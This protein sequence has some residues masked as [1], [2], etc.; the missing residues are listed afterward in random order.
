M[1]TRSWF[2]FDRARMAAALALMMFV[3]SPAAAQKKGGAIDTPA[4]S[5]T[6]ATQTSID[7]QVCAG[8]TTGAPAGFSLQWLTAEELAAGAD[9]VPG[10]ADDNQ[11]FAS[12]DAQLCKASF[13][14]NA[15]LSRYNLAAGE[16]VNVNVGEFLFD[17][18]ASTNCPGGLP[19]GRST[20][21][22]R[23]LMRQAL[24]CAAISRRSSRVAAR[25]RATKATK[26]AAR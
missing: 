6:G 1:Q 9:G 14:G 10:T 22:A 5:C 15:N 8:A 16:C 25:C 11:W 23:L 12:A 24:S 19:A 26:A 3:A 21:F 20:C 2:T 13:S 4:I 7:I 18:G 17:N